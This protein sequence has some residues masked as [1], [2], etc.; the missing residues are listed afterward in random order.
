ML[1]SPYRANATPG[2][3]QALAEAS[4]FGGGGVSEW[5]GGPFEATHK[6]PERMGEWTACAVGR[7]GCARM[8]SAVPLL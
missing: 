2:A 5:Y 1:F 8:G 3:I 6:T 4:R 7:D